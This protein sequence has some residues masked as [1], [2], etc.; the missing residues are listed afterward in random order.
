[1]PG[2]PSLRAY[3]QQ[4][5]EGGVPHE[6][7]LATVAAWDFEE[8]VRD[9]LVIEPMRQDNTFAVVYSAAAIGQITDED[10]DEI[11]RRINA[12]G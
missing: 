8:Q 1:M 5:A 12:R 6:E 7:M 9:E 3:L 10:I 4:Y 11:E 2:K